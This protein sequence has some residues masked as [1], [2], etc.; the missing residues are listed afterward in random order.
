M[1]KRG[2]KVIFE[3]NVIWEARKIIDELSYRDD[4]LMAFSILLT[5]E[6]MSYQMISEL[7]GVSISTVKRMNRDFREK[8]FTENPTV[9]PGWG[10]DRRSILSFDEES[11]IL[12]SLFEESLQGHL[13]TVA[14][15]KTK[16]EEKSNS[17][18]CIQTVYNIL[19]RHK[20]RKVVP[21]K[22]HPKNNPE[23]LDEFQKKR[24]PMRYSWQP[25]KLSPKEKISG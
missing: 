19:H 8:D 13:V 6:G 15:I 1:G 18:M 22:V 5:V 17:A 7:L 11:E 4:I 24:F 9:K 23:Q 3:E 25:E 10:G 16:L 14:N 2:K 12:D 20:W 21:D